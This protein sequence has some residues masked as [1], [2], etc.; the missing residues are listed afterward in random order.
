[1]RAHSIKPGKNVWVIQAG[2]EV[3]LSNDLQ[4][5]LSQFQ[6]VNSHWFGKNI[7]IFALTV[8]KP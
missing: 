5:E 7:A 6:S 2:W 3:N 4:R 1:M 8:R